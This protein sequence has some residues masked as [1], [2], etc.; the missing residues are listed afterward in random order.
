[1]ETIIELLMER[2][3]MSRRSATNLVN[4]T[5]DKIEDAIDSGDDPLDV[6]DF[7]LGLDEEYLSCFMI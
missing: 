1:M 5:Y 4:E 2:D 6:L 7:M 3:G